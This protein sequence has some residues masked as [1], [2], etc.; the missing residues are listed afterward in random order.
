MH[1]HLPLGDGVPMH[2]CKSF[3]NYTSQGSQNRS[4]RWYQLATGPVRTGQK[5][6]KIGPEASQASTVRSLLHS[7][8]LPPLEALNSGGGSASKPLEA[9]NSSDGSFVLSF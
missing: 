6:N 1:F 7:K 8:L 5:P 3:S 9:L 4:D 2:Q